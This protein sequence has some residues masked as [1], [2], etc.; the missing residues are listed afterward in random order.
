MHL[1]FYDNECPYCRK[2]I[3]RIIKMDKGKLFQFAP[4]NGETA[5]K[6][7][8]G[9]LAFYANANSVVLLENYESTDREFFIRAQAAL[10]I[11]WLMGKFLGIF[12]FLPSWMTDPFY[13]KIA[14]HRHKFKLK[15]ADEIV[16]KDR[17]LP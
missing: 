15:Y 12:A 6:I 13:R 10:R 17:F 2:A 3:G 7:L 16:P 14:E 9:P 5:Q 1:V 4:L 8:T 11:Y